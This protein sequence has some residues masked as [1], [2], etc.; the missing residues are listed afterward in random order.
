MQLF[1]IA[2]RLIHD[3]AY[4]TSQRFQRRFHALRNALANA[5]SRQ[6]KQFQ[7]ALKRLQYDLGEARKD[8]ASDEKVKRF[9]DASENFSR[10]V[11]GE[12][13]SV[14]SRGV[15]QIVKGPLEM[16]RDVTWDVA[17]YW[18]AKAVEMARLVVIPR[19]EFVNQEWDV[20]IDVSLSIVFFHTVHL[21][22][23]IQGFTIAPP[24]TGF[25]P[26]MV[27]L[28][29]LSDFSLHTVRHS[30]D[31]RKSELDVD[32]AAATYTRFRLRGVR[33]FA[34]DVS[35][36]VKRKTGWLRIEEEGY[37]DVVLGMGPNEGLNIDVEVGLRKDERTEGKT[38]WDIRR[39]E[40]KLE[41][42]AL[43]RTSYLGSSWRS[44]EF[45]N[46]SKVHESSHPHVPGSA[47]SSESHSSAA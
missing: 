8:V 25:L 6:S 26:T 20:A 19:I 5:A 14:R 18:I 44:T 21:N 41:V 24:D 13:E 46:L 37:A 11:V 45:C 33:G 39:V 1:R 38:R 30:S 36:Y 4:A 42:S 28:T 12:V 17:K 10:V 16:A 2:K 15:T 32:P 34:K 35:L 40:V 31:R 9:V 22:L 43:R 7:T 27:R 47:Y 23:S 29:N 3:P